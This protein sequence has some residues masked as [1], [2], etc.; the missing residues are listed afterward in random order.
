MLEIRGNVFFFFSLQPVGFP[1]VVIQ[2]LSRE[3]ER[4]RGAETSIHAYSYYEGEVIV[5]DNPD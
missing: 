4:D 2:L 1:N 5:P 3:R